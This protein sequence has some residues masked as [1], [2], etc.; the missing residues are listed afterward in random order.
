MFSMLSQYT[1]H[2]EE[3]VK[4]RQAEL[5]NEKKEVENML[6]GILPRFLRLLYPC[7]STA[8]Y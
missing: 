2:M 5:H 3:L 1:D 8:F 6:Y 4:Q 7:L